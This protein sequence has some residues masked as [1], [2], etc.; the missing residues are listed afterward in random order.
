MPG[1]PPSYTLAFV[2]GDAVTFK[3]QITD[4]DLDDPDSAAVSR[5]LTGWTA[6][7]QIRQS[8]SSQEVLATWTIVSLGADGVVTMHLSGDDTEPLAAIKTMVSDVELTDPDGDPQTVLTIDIQVS[9][10]VTRD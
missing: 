6:R 4:K 8:A 9:Q 2:A 10:D 5:D 7:S 3:F 1:L